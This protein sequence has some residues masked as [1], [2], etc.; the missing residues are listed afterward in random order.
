M[1]AK[2]LLKALAI[3]RERFIDIIGDLIR[4]GFIVEKG[5]YIYIKK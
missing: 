4:E 5:D 1:S 3:P 2:E